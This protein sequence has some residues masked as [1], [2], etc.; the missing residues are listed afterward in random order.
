[1]FT[2]KPSWYLPKN[3]QIRE[4]IYDKWPIYDKSGR[5]IIKIS[6]F[7]GGL[8]SLVTIA[9]TSGIGLNMHISHPSFVIFPYELSGLYV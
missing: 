4:T 7:R 8:N 9:K 5:F 2:G 1:M 6:D 3:A